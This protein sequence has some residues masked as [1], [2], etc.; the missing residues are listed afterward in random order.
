MS[1]LS[2]SNV[3]LCYLPILVIADPPDI[4]VRMEN[5]DSSVTLTEIL[6]SDK[7]KSM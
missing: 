1:S 4:I 7:A 3:A 2:V 6:K 5:N